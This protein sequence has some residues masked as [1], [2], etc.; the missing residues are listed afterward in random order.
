M[1]IVTISSFLK[2][3]ESYANLGNK[4]KSLESTKR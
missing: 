3:E 4:M 1:N 2:K